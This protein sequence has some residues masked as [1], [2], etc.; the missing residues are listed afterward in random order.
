MTMITPIV[1]LAILIF[2]SGIASGSETALF[3]LSPLKVKQFQQEGGKRRKLIVQL[4]RRPRDL[5]V[6]ILIINI[7]V[8]VLVQN[9]VSEV[10]GAFSGWLFTVGVPLCL[11]LI[12]GEVLPKSIA[13]AHNVKISLAVSHFFYFL[14]WLLTPIRVVFTK[15]AGW[16]SHVLFFFLKSEK[17]IS[18]DEL[19][20]ALRTSRDYG[21][22]SAD[23][24][25][26]IRGSLNLDEMLVK[27]LMRPRIEIIYFDLSQPITDLLS[28]FIDQECSRVPI[29]DGDLENV[30]GIMTS[31]LFFLHQSKIHTSQD[32]RRFVRESYFIPETLGA[33]DLFIQFREKKESI[34]LVINEYGLISGIVSLEDIVEI[35]VGQIDDKRDEEHLFTRASEDVIIASGKM[36]L[37]ELEEIFDISINSKTNMATVGGF[38]T[39]H[40]GDIPQSGSKYIIDNILFNVLASSKTKVLK[41]YIRKLSGPK[42]RSL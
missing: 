22:I 14:R 34:A 11:T 33:R 42:K 6:T 36:E 5:L 35:V 8:N 27:E 7:A 38:L 12:F 30:I 31:D 2:I 3:S 21:I 37:S 23:E 29:I 19:K 20:H 9:I 40:V 15:I 4:L 16:L 25:K 18:V 24:A 32:L 17:E 26:L 28:I 41:I 39:E 1:I 10:F 13:I